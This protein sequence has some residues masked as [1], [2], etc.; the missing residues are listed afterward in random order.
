VSIVKYD[1]Y[2]TEDAKACGDP[3]P[4]FVEFFERH[5]RTPVSV[6]DLGCGQGRD[7]LFIARLGHTV[8]G[9]G[10]SEVGVRQMLDTAR[11]E[12]L[13][14]EAVVA[15]AS[16][17]RSRCKYD[18][19]LLDRVVHQLSDRAEQERLLGN[20]ARLT[21]KDGGGTGRAGVRRD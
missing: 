19:V 17:Y 14:I 8:F 10:I 1:K 11:K 15:D 5:V 16:T 4:A 9:V 18:V 7:A 13:D 3:Y 6:L 20:A 21:R 2:Y 12:G